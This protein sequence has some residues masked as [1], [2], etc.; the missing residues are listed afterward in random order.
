MANLAVSFQ[1]TTAPGALAPLHGLLSVVDDVTP[2]DDRWM[3]GLAFS[4]ETGFSGGSF[5]FECAPIITSAFTEPVTAHAPIEN[6]AVGL[7]SAFECGTFGWEAIDYPERATRQLEAINS[8]ILEYE[9]WTGTQVSTNQTLVNTTP[10]T[11]YANGKGILGSG[12]VTAVRALGW[13]LDALSY[14]PS[15]RGTIH[16]TQAIVDGWVL[17]GSVERVGDHLETTVGGHYVA[18]GQ[19]YPG[20]GPI[21]AATPTAEQSW[22][23]ATSGRVRMRLSPIALLPGKL[24]EA[25]DRSGNLIRF[26]GQQIYLADW[27]G[28]V[29]AAVLVTKPS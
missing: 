2:T 10:N 29:S 27:D 16:A 18:A 7:E 14:G 17:N 6:Q 9:F 26:R 23:F 19:G 8:S 20:T 13:L 25:L 21:G 1:P 28:V 15:G 4:P 12:A 11:A 3:G 22:A 5:S 24:S